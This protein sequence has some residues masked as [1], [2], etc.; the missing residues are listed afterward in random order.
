MLALGNQM[1]Q[2]IRTAVTLLAA[3]VFAAFAGG[4]SYRA[5]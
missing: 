3:G 5:F 1:S 4:A 2:R